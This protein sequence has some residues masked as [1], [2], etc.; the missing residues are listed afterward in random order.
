MGYFDYSR[1]PK[2]DIA[3]VDMKSF[4]ASV[5]CVER[6]LHP[7]KTSLCVM[8]RQ[9]NTS[10]VILASSPMFKKVF[11]K[12]N[13]SR[14]YDLPFDIHTRKFSFRNAIKQGLPTTPEY[15]AYIEEWAKDTVIVSP[16]MSLYIEKNIEIQHVFQDYASTEDILPYSI[17]EGFIDLTSSLNYFVK[18]KALTRRQKLD[19]V[20]AKIQK[21]IWR[22][23][24]IYSTIGM[25]NSN[26]LLAKLALD[27]EAKKTPT[28]R[29]NWSYEDVETKVW[30]I[31]NMTDFWGIGRR[32]EKRLNKLGIYSIKD[33]ANC[34]SDILKK[35]FGVVGM[36]LFFHANGIDESNVHKP[37][38]AKSKGLGNS[39][40]LPRDYDRQ[41]EIELVLREMAEQVAIRL[42]RAHKKTSRVSVHVGY[43]RKEEKRP[44][45]G[46]MKIEPTNNTKE[47]MN[48]VL[49]IFHSKYDSGSVRSIGVYYSGF[50]DE[51]FGLISLFDDV[52]KIEK[53]ERL[54]SAIDDIRNQFGFT[55]LQ[56]ANALQDA[57][58]VI[59]R[60][61]LVGGH[62][63]GGLDGLK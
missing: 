62:S 28:M 8:S 63:A 2:S 13:V 46:Q 12:Q 58:R 35:E 53:E 10:G 36:D 33:L 49:S 39:Q 56:K 31:P 21:D 61:K 48:H 27:N 45:Q 15:I 55:M 29:A 1:E 41:W 60:S 20:S 51:S 32:T 26:P 25:S 23:T 37:Y 38:K 14:A 34:N 42:R 50:V 19:I 57:S 59:A 43:S 24:G 7:L 16:R 22:K 4:Y 30:A 11:G 44:L 18:D 17:D 3:F 9:D 6:G 5:E 54:Q 40:I 52:E 47:L